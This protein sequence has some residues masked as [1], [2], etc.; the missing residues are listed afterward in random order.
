MLH[1]FLFT[2][3]AV[4]Q[5]TSALG[6][7]PTVATQ[8]DAGV[9]WSDLANALSDDG[10][11]ATASLSATDQ[12]TQTLSLSGFGLAIPA[13]AVIAGLEVTVD[14]AADG[15]SGS[16]GP[17]LLQTH[18]TKAGGFSSF[19]KVLAAMDPTDGATF[20]PTL[21]TAGGDDDLWSTTWTPAEVNDPDFAL[22][23]RWD[24]AGAD[25]AG[26]LH[27]DHVTVEVTIVTPSMDAGEIMASRPG[28]YYEGE[29]LELIAPPGL[30]HQWLRDGEYLGTNGG[31]LDLAPLTMGHTGNYSVVFTTIT[32]ELA[33]AP[34]FALVVLP[35]PALPAMEIALILFVV[36]IVLG[37][38][39]RRA[40]SM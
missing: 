34:P 17:I 1:N 32:K 25:A 19:P 9:P 29:G 23:L 11:D 18:F 3:L 36:A 40:Q 4:I 27:I 6:A 14:V 7:S 2:G 38:G 21:L 24:K 8:H 31:A 16:L 30:D 26:T 39:W 10:A 15:L 22:E 5:A 28:P 12:A 20:G 37:V 13:G 33:A 35:A